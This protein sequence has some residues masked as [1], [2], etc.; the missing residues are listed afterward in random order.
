MAVMLPGEYEIVDG[1]GVRDIVVGDFLIY[2]G[3][4]SFKGFLYKLLKEQFMPW[5]IVH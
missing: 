1:V 4:Y 2:S 5:R 3:T